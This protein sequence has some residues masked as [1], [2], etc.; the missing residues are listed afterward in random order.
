[1]WGDDGSTS[2]TDTSTAGGGITNQFYKVVRIPPD[3]GFN[4]DAIPSGWAV[5]NG[6]NPLDPNLDTEDPDGDGQNNFDEYVADTSPTNSSS[7]FH[8]ID[9]LTVGS[10]IRV[11]FTSSSNRYYN[12]QRSAFVSGPY[13]NVV[14]NIP[15]NGGIQWAK[16]IGAASFGDWYRV[17]V[18]LTNLPP[19]TDSDGIPDLWT[20]QYFGHPTGLAADLSRATDNPDDDC[21][22]NLQEFLNGSDPTNHDS[23][24]TIT[25]SASVCPG[26]TLNLSA[27]TIPGAS[28]SWSGPNGFTSTN[29]N[30]S[31]PNA[32]TNATGI[33]CVSATTTNCMST[34]CAS[35]TVFPPPTAMV[36]GSIT[37]CSGSPATISVELTGTGP[38]IVSWSDGIIESNITLNPWPRTVSPYHATNFTVVA[39]SDAHHCS[40]G[41]G[42]GTATITVT[43]NVTSSVVVS[44]EVLVVYNSNLTDSVSCANYY[45]AHRP[46]FSNANVLAC[47]CTTTGT[48][49]FEA[50]SPGNLTNQIINP[51]ITFMQSNTNKSIHYVV[52]MY[53][54]PSRVDDGCGGCTSPPSVQNH[55]SRCMSGAG[56]TSGPYYEGSTCPFVATNYLGTTCLVTALNL[57]TL[58]DCTAYIDKLTSMYTSNVIISAKAAGYGNNNY[59]LDEYNHFGTGGGEDIEAGPF[60]TAILG[61]NPSASVTYSTST[62]INAGTNVKGYTGWGTHNSVF[63]AAYPTNGIVAWSGSSTWWIIETFESFNGQ[64]DAAYPYREPPQGD[65]EEWFA[66]NAWGGADYANTPVGA[67][68]HV[69]EPGLP[70]VNGPTYMSLWEAGY[71]FSECAWASKNTPCFQAIGDPLIR[72]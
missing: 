66:S 6:L 20:E 67:V 69:E 59:Y 38:W 51:I 26:E 11:F 49:G 15:G 27:L 18:F 37:N 64:R 5:D 31:I 62:Y 40:G 43:T 8:V 22:N 13:S 70:G 48:D 41:T 29:Q 56:Y 36:S 39:V 10:D 65:V 42:S 44:N 30:P 12:L 19:D 54:M 1:M 46:G 23:G 25:G 53:G 60:R 35:V 45:I 28:Y 21:F 50:I 34:N 24:V 33:Y 71:L 3:E 4:G 47:S 55:I 72:Q 7:Y 52:L 68:S 63:D 58:A 9:V 32:T 61:A 2:W 17:S 57:A 16:D 14:Q